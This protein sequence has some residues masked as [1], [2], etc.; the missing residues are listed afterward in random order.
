MADGISQLQRSDK[1]IRSVVVDEF[2]R[3]EV[4]Q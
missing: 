3:D 1:C 4:T 2:L